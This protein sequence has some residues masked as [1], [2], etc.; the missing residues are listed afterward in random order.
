MGANKSKRSNVRTG[1]PY[2][3]ETAL[4]AIQTGLA[5]MA[6]AG[7]K[8]LKATDDPNVLVVNGIGSLFVTSI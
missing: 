8:R 4:A 6:G 7:A 1:P 3:Y 2:T 5:R